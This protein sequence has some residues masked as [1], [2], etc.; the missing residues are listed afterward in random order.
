LNVARWPLRAIS[1]Q[2]FFPQLVMAVALTYGVIS[3]AAAVFFFAGA[4]LP[5]NAQVTTLLKGDES[6]LIGGTSALI[7]AGCAAMAAVKYF[8]GRKRRAY[9]LFELGLL[10]NILIGQVVLFFKSQDIA[11]AWL[12]LTL[13]LLLNL[14]ALTYSSPNSV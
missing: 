2:A 12:A 5:D 7:S 3:I 1:R 8:E 10:V 14:K 4:A 6:D 13:F 9:K 11:L